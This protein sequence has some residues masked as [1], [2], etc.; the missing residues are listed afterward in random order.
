MSDESNDPFAE[1]DDTPVAGSEVD[2]L[3][4]EM[5][6]E[7]IDEDDLWEELTADD[8]L[9]GI[10]EDAFEEAGPEEPTIEGDEAV[11]SKSRY[12]QGCAYF[13]D[14][15]ETACEHEGTD[16]LELVDIKHFRVR[17]CP[18]VA[19]RQGSTNVFDDE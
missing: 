6:V 11:V 14:P 7:E 19:E 9:K 16:I 4:T 8:P 15:P 5:E 12:C 17:N 3:F 10:D 18:V 2:E 1:L 13:S